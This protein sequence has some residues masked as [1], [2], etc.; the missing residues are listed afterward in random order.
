[1]FLNVV[2]DGQRFLISIVTM[3]LGG[4]LLWLG[5]VFFQLY[6]LR[7]Y[8]KKTREVVAQSLNLQ[9]VMALIASSMFFAFSVA[10]FVFMKVY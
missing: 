4:T 8:S 6:V 9:G 3:I 1:M 5:I 7:K 2:F 10:M